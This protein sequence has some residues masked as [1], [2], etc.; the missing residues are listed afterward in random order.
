MK[1]KIQPETEIKYKIESEYGWLEG[2]YF[3]N[4]ALEHFWLIFAQHVNHKQEPDYVDRSTQFEPYMKYAEGLLEHFAR[5]E[6]ENALKNLVLKI[7]AQALIA[8]DGVTPKEATERIN[9]LADEIKREVKRDMNAPKR[10]G[11]RKELERE[12]FTTNEELISYAE[13]VNSLRPLWEHITRFFRE[14]DYGLSCLSDVRQTH[15]FNALSQ[16]CVNV[17]DDLLRNVYRRER[18]DL[19][20]EKTKLALSPRG[21]ALE[22]ARRELG[23]GRYAAETLKKRFLEGRKLLKA[24]TQKQQPSFTQP[25]QA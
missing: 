22:H 17:P 20:D 1:V 19:L 24:A 15:L 18:F 11:A 14:R 9:K 5:K 16:V 21:L 6:F 2:T 4:H 13:A 23:I 12:Y 3:P 25:P 7:E 10:G 8:V